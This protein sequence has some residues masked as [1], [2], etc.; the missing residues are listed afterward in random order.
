MDIEAGLNRVRA[1]KCEAEKPM[2]RRAAEA[3]C[4]GQ[5]AFYKYLKPGRYELEVFSDI[6][7]EME[8]FAGQRIAMAGDFVSGRGQTSRVGGWPSG[9][10][11]EAGDPVICDLSPRV[12]RYSGDSCASATAGEPTPG[13]LKLFHAAK[14]ALMHAVSIMRPGLRIDGSRCATPRDRAA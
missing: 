10:R 6:R 1:V 3:A 9:R 4:V 14:T 13:F 2:L 12:G 5:N 11:I 7:R 8:M